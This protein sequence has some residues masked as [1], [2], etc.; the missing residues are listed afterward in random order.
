MEKYKIDEVN[1]LENY[2]ESLKDIIEQ[3]GDTEDM[4][5]FKEDIKELNKW[6]KEL[7]STGEKHID[8]DWKINMLTKIFEFEKDAELIPSGDEELDKEGIEVQKEYV[9]GIEEWLNDL[10]KEMKNIKKVKKIKPEKK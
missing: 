2:V 8:I 4:N 3:E 6:I 5:K 9:E 10:K 1:V 7:K